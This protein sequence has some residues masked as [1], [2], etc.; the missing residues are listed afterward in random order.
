LGSGNL[1]KLIQRYCANPG[2]RFA[3]KLNTFLP[4]FA[5]KDLSLD[6]DKHLHN[7][8]R[9]TVYRMDALQHLIDLGQW[10][11]DLPLVVRGAE[12][13]SLTLNA[14]PPHCYDGPQPG[15]RVLA[16]QT[17]PLARGLDVRLVQLGLSA[18][19]VDIKADGVFGQGSRDQIKNYQAGHGLPETG[20]ADIAL[21]VQLT[22]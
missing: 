7:I 1:A 19:G 16:V 17:T 15:T 4:R 9:A 13:S 2:A 18:L 21:I 3:A 22:A 10:G 12:I 6:T 14:T 20:I 5:A 8:L 11:M